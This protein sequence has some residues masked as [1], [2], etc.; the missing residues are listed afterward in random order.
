MQYVQLGQTDM[1][2][3]RVSFGAIPIRRL[4][5]AGAEKVILQSIERGINFFDTA[6][7]YGDSEE[8]LGAAL[9]RRRK[10]I[11]LA[12][13]SGKR[14]AD[15][16]TEELHTSLKN[17][18]T[19]YVDLYQL[20][21]VRTEED[22]ETVFGPDGAMEAVARAQSQGK[23][24]SIGITSHDEA[25][26]LR[27]IDS[28]EFATIMVPFNFMESEF[29][30]EVLPA[31]ADAQMGAIIMKPFAGGMLDEASLA[32][33]YVLTFSEDAV[34][35]PGMAALDEVQENTEIGAV[36]EP[37]SESER[38]RLEAQRA[39]LGSEFCRGCEYCQPCPNDV[40]ISRVL[41]SERGL[42]R[43]GQS[44]LQD[45][46][47]EIEDNVERCDECETCRPRCPYDLDI[48]RLLREK[49]EILQD[50]S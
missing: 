2:V 23:I 18:R 5:F 48:P 32:L 33:R 9:G 20:H 47:A 50:Y 49:R 26:S 30:E 25:I 44:W 3:S 41:R 22:Y 19:D 6:R 29:G 1:R 31:A 34:A 14:T 8:M 36:A 35:I 13:K 11:F 17:L 27:A 38:G 12:T 4:S 39:Q 40:D 46:L 43:L 7:G 45:N 15:E 42:R 24:R 16:L 28:G 37:L 10:D 21:N